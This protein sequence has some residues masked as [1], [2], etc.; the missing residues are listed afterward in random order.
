MV[1]SAN[2]VSLV[3]N[4]TN[5]KP[6]YYTNTEVYNKTQTNTLYNNW[7]EAAIGA[8]VGNW[9]GNASLYTLNTNLVATVGNWSADKASYATVV[10]VTGLNTSLQANLSAIN[11]TFISNDSGLQARIASLNTSFAANISALNLTSVQTTNIVA[12]VGNWTADKASYATV[13]QVTGLNTSLQANLSAI[14]LTFIS[15][16][17]GLQARIASLNTSFA[18]N[19]SALNLTSVSTGNIVSLVG[20]WTADKASYATVTQVTGLNTSLQAN[21]S[22]INLTFIS[23][24][25]GMQARIGSLN[26]SF[27]L[28]IT[29]L[30]TSKASVTQLTGMNTSLQANISSLN[31]SKAGLGANTF[32]GNQT[33]Q[34]G[35]VLTTTTTKSACAS[36]IRGTFWVDQ[37][38]GGVADKLYICMKNSSDAYNWALIVYGG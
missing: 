11:L 28:N 4:W 14:N 2:V 5:D 9:S 31:I 34:S 15:N 10:Q 29:D 20:N 26:S 36:G 32:T 3:G 16:D 38:A 6:S 7:T 25:S 35:L 17:S 1:T 27:A 8:L 37:G 30:N 21:L 12:L 22:A 33:L 23:N 13:T 19:I 24:D 18:A